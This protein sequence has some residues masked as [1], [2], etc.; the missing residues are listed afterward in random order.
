MP[1]SGLVAEPGLVEVIPGSGEIL[2]KSAEVRAGCSRQRSL[3]RVQ[4]LLAQAYAL[5]RG[6]PTL[7]ELRGNQTIVGIARS[8]AA[9]RERGFIASLLQL[10]FSDA[11]LVSL[12]FHVPLFRLQCSFD[13]HRLDGAQQ[14]SSNGFVGSPAAESKAP[15]L[16]ILHIRAIASIHRVAQSSPRIRHRQ[17]SPAATASINGRSR[18]P[19]R[20]GCR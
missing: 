6:L 11:T 9:L 20:P 7:L 13:G 5:K 19:D 12:N 15:R 14:L 18:S 2:G 16:R 8:V 3:S 17:T 4:A 10:E 1:G